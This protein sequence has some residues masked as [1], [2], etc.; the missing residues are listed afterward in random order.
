MVNEKSIY[1]SLTRARM[2]FDVKLDEHVSGEL[3]YDHEWLFGTLDHALATPA[4]ATRV[5]QARILNGNAGW[6][7]RMALQ[8]EWLG[9]SDHDPVIVDLRLIQASTSD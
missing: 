6:P 4:L 5:T 8:P 2:R 3:V 1:Q 9:V 7:R